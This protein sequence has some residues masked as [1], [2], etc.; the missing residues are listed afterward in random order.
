MGDFTAVSHPKA[1]KPHRCDVCFRTIGPG[2]KYDRRA[3]CWDGTFGVWKECPHC[4]ALI[5][6]YDIEGWDD[7]AP[8]NDD[9]SQWEPETIPGLR[10][11]VHWRKRWRRADGTLYPIPAKED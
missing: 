1:R 3:G 9:V 11:M 5:Q 6:V 10:A 4:V 8:G 7:Y 2:E